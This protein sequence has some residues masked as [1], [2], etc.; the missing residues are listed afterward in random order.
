MV[1][2]YLNAGIGERLSDDT[3]F[4]AFAAR[5]YISTCIGQLVDNLTFALIVSRTFFGWTLSQCLTCALTGAVLELV[6]EVVFSPLGY[7]LTQSILAERASA[8]AD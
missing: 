8:N 3:G 4:K 1:N 7:R 5:A 2:N 6:F